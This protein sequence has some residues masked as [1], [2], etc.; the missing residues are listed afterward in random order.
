M[1]KSKIGEGSLIL[2]FWILIWWFISFRGNDLIIPSPK[3]TMSVLIGLSIKLETYTIIGMS[4]FRVFISLIIGI[5]LGILFG[6]LAGLS[7]WVRKL[8]QPVVLVIKSTPVVSFIIILLVYV[9]RAWVPSICGMLLCFPIIYSN[10]LEGY[11]MV[12]DQLISMSNVYKV[13]FKRKLQKLYL[14][15]TLPYL[16]AGILTS[17]GIC[18]KATI[19]AEV[20]SFLDNSIGYQILNGKVTIEYDHIFAW[21]IIIILCSLLIEVVAKYLI[22]KV[23]YYERFRGI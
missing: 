10:M 23:N 12:D 2:L 3:Q 1:K 5:G 21:T 22:K 13:P 15:S 4:L 6:M 11:K 7:D 18:W 19:A 9:D 8:I 20:I 16:Y 14:P 17:I